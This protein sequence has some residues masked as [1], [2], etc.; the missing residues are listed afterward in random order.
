MDKDSELTIFMTLWK[1]EEFT[2][3]WMSYVNKIHFPFKILI[4]DGGENKKI[5]EHL[6]NSKN[7]P[8]IR[9][10][11]FR[12]PYDQSYDH[13]YSK[14]VDALSQV[15]TP[16]VAMAN[17][18]DFYFVEGLRKSVEFLLT[19]KEYSS[20]GGKCVGF[21]FSSSRD[22]TDAVYGEKI[23][24]NFR[25]DHSIEYDSACDRIMTIFR[26]PVSLFYNVQRTHNLKH[27]YELVKKY[28]LK[29]L[30]L[31]E[32]FLNSLTVASGK[33][34][35]EPSY[36]HIMR[37]TKT[38]QSA[39]RLHK[40]KY[41]DHFD[42][43]LL[44]TWSEDFNNF[45]NITADFLT[46][47]DDISLDDAARVVKDGYKIF[48]GFRMVE[49]FPNLLNNNEVAFRNKFQTLGKYLGPKNQF[50]R[51]VLT[52]LFHKLTSQTKVNRG[53][54]FPMAEFNRSTP[55]YEDIKPIY[56]FLSF[57]IHQ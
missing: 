46:Q 49:C 50:P 38:S 2:Y 51:N 36:L 27:I 22:L 29:D 19:N 48:S 39:A 40:Q 16:F 42:R 21:G 4:A 6:S 54:K 1:Q 43:M 8:N 28:Y 10:K 57:K 32:L 20:C 47:Y 37:Q 14:V 33:V 30:F 34:K 35:M 5:A 23:Y 26:T 18:D 3:R 45:L 13:Y 31:V 41:G 12:Y 7:Y 55:F 52:K 15:D 11:Y 56:D 24:L 53:K 25:N 17:N 44:D 9:Y